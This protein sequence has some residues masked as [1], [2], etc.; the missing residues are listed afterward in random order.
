[1]ASSAPET[2]RS[3]PRRWPRP[4]RARRLPRHRRTLRPAPRSTRRPPRTQRPPRQRTGPSIGSPAR[5]F[6]RASLGVVKLVLLHPLPLDGSIWPEQVTA[7]AEECVVPNLYALGDNIQDWARAVIDFAGV[8][9][10]T[11]V[12]NSVGGSC[13]IEM[14]LAAPEKVSALVLSGTKAGHD[15]DPAFRD[16]A[17]RLV[18]ERGTEAAW[19][20]YWEPL[21]GPGSDA[22]ARL[23]REVA[24]AQGAPAIANGVRVFHSRTDRDWFLDWWTG[25]V[26]GGLGRARHPTGTGASRSETAQRRPLSRGGRGRTLCPS[27]SARGVRPDRRRGATSRLQDAPGRPRSPASTSAH[28]TSLAMRTRQ[29]GGHVVV[30]EV[31]VG[32]VEAL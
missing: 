32:Y 7:L 29:G 30:E 12:G 31:A 6:K 23:A 9:P 2:H 21:F 13:A 4:L 1:V 19:E 5:R 10:M 14:A 18:D 28:P 27:G 22:A 25:P 15:P 8:G 11:L 20:R 3:R 17:L 26:W 24:M 16:E